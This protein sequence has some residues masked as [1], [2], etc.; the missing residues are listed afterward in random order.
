VPLVLLQTTICT[1]GLQ[2]VGL[3]QPSSRVAVVTATTGATVHEAVGTDR[4]TARL[5]AAS[6]QRSARPVTS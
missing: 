2:S 4:P 5:Q 3:L 6:K 1:D